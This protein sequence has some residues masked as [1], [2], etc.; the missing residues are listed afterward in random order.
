MSVG[1]YEI[2]KWQK[3]VDRLVF[4]FDFG[5]PYRIHYKLPRQSGVST[6]LVTLANRLRA[7]GYAVL[8][9]APRREQLP[10][11]HF[12]P[13]IDTVTYADRNKYVGGTKYDFALMDV[14]LTNSDNSELVNHLRLIARTI[15]HLETI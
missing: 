6:Y 2:Q 11:Q 9:V 10:H 14:P 1:N 4:D 3:H 5:Q 15:I 12:I 13:G 8:F 7:K